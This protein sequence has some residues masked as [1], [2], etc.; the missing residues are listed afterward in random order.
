MTKTIEQKTLKFIDEYHLIEKGDKVLVAL[1][2]GADSIFLLSFLIKF[3]KR[4]GLEAAA[5][6]LNHKLRGKSADADEKF[7]SEFCRQNKIKFILWN[8]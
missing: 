2:G 6:H 4:F 1:S 5:F 3:K 8:I 7:C